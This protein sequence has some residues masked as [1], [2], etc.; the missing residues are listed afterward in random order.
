MNKQEL[1]KI[2]KAKR[3]TIHS[4]ERLRLDDLLL[5]QF[6]QFDY[7]AMQTVLSYWPFAG[8][9]EPNTHLFSGYLRHMLPGMVLA[10]PLIDPATYQMTALAIH[11]D[12]IYHTNPWGVTEPKEGAVIDPEKIDLIFVP[13]LAYDQEG[14]RVGYGKGFYDRYL[15]NCREDIVKIGFS[16]FD[17]VDKITDTDQFDVPLTY[18]ITPQQT[19]EF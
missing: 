13:L 5:L 11:E 2:Y 7:S 4:K 8:K 3:D 19:Y 16:Y 14:F 6:Q 12:T 10:Y 18:C 17:P 9:S 15:A 1:R